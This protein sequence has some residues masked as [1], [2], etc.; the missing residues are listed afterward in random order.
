[1]RLEP[2]LQGLLAGAPHSRGG[3][4]PA[5]PLGPVEDS[6]RGAIGGSYGQCCSLDS[7]G[8][9]VSAPEALWEL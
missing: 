2:R 9:V 7:L 1:M 3:H 8:V 5:V 6:Q 4:V